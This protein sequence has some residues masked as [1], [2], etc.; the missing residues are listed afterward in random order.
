MRDAL[1]PR[2]SSHHCIAALQRLHASSLGQGPNAS[3]NQRAAGR[4][5][6][7]VHTKRQRWL[8]S[9]LFPFQD[10]FE[11]G[12]FSPGLIL[13]ATTAPRLLRA[14]ANQVSQLGAVPMGSGG[15]FQ[16]LKD[17]FSLT[18]LRLTQ[19]MPSGQRTGPV[20]N[21]SSVRPRGF[22]CEK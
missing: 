10:H 13:P 22:D 8:R 18:A 11:L 20:L 12:I 15:T 21:L 14:R 5:L 2:A 6:S 19:F 9:Q 4:K 17:C 16:H 1:R 7:I 3:L